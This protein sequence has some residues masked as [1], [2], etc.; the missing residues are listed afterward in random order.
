MTGST[1]TT[2]T[3]YF[4]DAENNSTSAVN[5]VNSLES[6]LPPSKKAKLSKV[7]AVSPE[8]IQIKMELVEKN[9]TRLIE[10]RVERAKAH[11][12]E[13]VGAVQQTKKEFSQNFSMESNKEPVTLPPHLQKRIESFSPKTTEQIEAN[14]KTVEANHAKILEE[15]VEKVKAHNLNDLAAVQER[16]KEY[17]ENFSL[18]SN[19]IPVKLPANLQKRLDSFP[20]PS[21]EQILEKLA[22]ADLN[23]KKI[24]ETTVNSQKLHDEHVKEVLK[25]KAEIKATTA[26]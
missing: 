7:S 16:K 15:R 23:R 5:N 3:A 24:L 26:E 22:N 9:H 10:E 6:Q 13:A 12:V 14:L 8:Q 11:N 18:E 19:K 17:S 4:L 25:R 2:N 21:N 20:K 1:T